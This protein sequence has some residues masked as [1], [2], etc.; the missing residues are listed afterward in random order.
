M[1]LWIR[2]LAQSYW[3][4]SKGSVGSLPLEALGK[5]IFLCPLQLLGEPTCLHPPYSSTFKANNS[6]P[7]TS[8]IISFWPPFL[9]PPSSS[10]DSLCLTGC[11]QLTR[12]MSYC[13]ASWLTTLMPSATVIPFLCNITHRFQGLGCG[14]RSLSIHFNYLNIIIQ[15]FVWQ[16][17]NRRIGN[18]TLCLLQIT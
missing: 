7:S 8:H 15:P 9:P 17:N 18:H 13:K 14:W 6:R 1:V 11:T 16:E 2:G 3:V 10:K 12:M 5:N 4:K